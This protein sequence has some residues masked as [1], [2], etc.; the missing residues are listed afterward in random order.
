MLYL[1]YGMNT[2]REAMRERC[3][4]AKPLGGFFLPNHR[5]VFRGV[6]DYVYDYDCILPVVLWEITHDCLK[7]LDKLEGYPTLYNRVKVNEHRWWI[8]GM[9]DK[10]RTATPSRHY[11]D[12]IQQGY[13][14]FG[15]D[16]YQLRGARRQTTLFDNDSRYNLSKLFEGSA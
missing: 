14:D 8:Y 9:N 6:A 1:A 4:R 7:A 5:L 12:M 15:L 10:S 16:D 11:Y 2:N 13:K 3:P